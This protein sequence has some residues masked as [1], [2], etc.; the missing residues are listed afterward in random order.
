MDSAWALVFAVA[1]PFLC[2]GLL[3][4]L[5]RLEDTL[6]DGLAAPKATRDPAVKCAPV[7]AEASSAAAA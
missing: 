5:A 2:L 6:T 7:P 1:V 4:W 3:L